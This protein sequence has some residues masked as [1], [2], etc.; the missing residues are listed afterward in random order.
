MTSDR[1]T[2]HAFGAD[3]PAWAAMGALAV[4]QGAHLHT[5]MSRALQ[6][7]AGTVVAALLAWILLMQD[8]AVWT[9]ITVLILL[10]IATEMV[11]GVNCAFG[12][13]FWSHRWRC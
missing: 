1:R 7:T 5:T 12:Q 13:R 4:M 6:R 11:I 8:P 10:Q 2:S 3:H 9:V